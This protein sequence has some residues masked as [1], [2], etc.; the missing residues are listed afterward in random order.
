MDIAD[1]SVTTFIIDITASPFTKNITD[2]T[3]IADVTIVMDI[4]DITDVT[5]TTD[6]RHYG[7]NRHHCHTGIMSIT[8]IPTIKES[9]DISIVVITNAT[10][11]FIND[12]TA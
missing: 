2:I 1:I 9:T 10:L 11:A 12:I 5:A 6:I 7:H 8:N 4:T 3:V